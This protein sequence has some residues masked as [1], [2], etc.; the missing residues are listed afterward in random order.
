M[1]YRFCRFGENVKIVHFIGNSKPWLQYFNSETLQVTPS[2]GFNH[3]QIIFDHW[4][5]LF[6]AHVHSNLA[7]SM[8]R[9]MYNYVLCL[10]FYM[11][12]KVR[13]FY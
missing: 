13:F 3:L 11:C 9:N 6:C 7:A 2:P 4:W 1:I 5:N 10:T 8:V 12:V